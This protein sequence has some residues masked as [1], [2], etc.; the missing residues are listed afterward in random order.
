MCTVAKCKAH[1]KDD[2]KR[3]GGVLS[4]DDLGRIASRFNLTAKERAELV[5]TL[6]QDGIEISDPLTELLVKKNQENLKYFQIGD[7][8]EYPDEPI[9]T[10]EQEMALARRFQAAVEGGEKLD[11][12]ELGEQYSQIAKYGREAQAQLI[13]SNVRLVSLRLKRFISVSRLSHEDLF[14]EG[15]LGLFRAARK[16]DPERGFRFATYAA[17]WIDQFIRRAIAEKDG[18]IRVPIHL[19]NQLLTLKRAQRKVALSSGA[20]PTSEALAREMGVNLESV[21]LLLAVQTDII[22][23]DRE[24]TQDGMSLNTLL[25]S[26]RRTPKPDEEYERNEL[27]ETLRRCLRFLR[28]RRRKVIEWRFGLDGKKPKTLEQIGIRLHI[29]RERVRQIEKQALEE[30]AKVQRREQLGLSEFLP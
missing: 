27:R 28:P 1:L 29:T 7:V 25:A 20:K 17:W 26:S 2:Y 21:E 23:L 11:D 15:M 13:L 14:Q 5:L 22:S 3:Q 24:V 30:I 10:H 18:F 6:K 9:L 19:Q 4:V 16:Y 12:D 8:I